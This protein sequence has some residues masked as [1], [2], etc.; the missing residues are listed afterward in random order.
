M[1]QDSLNQNLDSLNQEWKEELITGII[2]SVIKSKLLQSVCLSG[3]K[4]VLKWMFS[5]PAWFWFAKEKKKKA[6][7]KPQ[8]NQ[9]TPEHNCCHILDSCPYR[10]MPK[11]ADAIFSP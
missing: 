10:E 8:Q 3:K 7:I 2:N 6:Q 1:N 9:N 5:G 11:I 4:C